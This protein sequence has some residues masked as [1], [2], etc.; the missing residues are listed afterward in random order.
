VHIAAGLLLPVLI[1]VHVVLGRRSRSERRN[2]V[3]SR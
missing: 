2:Q 3:R 1:L